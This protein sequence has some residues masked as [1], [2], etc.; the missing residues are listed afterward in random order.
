MRRKQMPKAQR[1]PYRKRSYR[2]AYKK[3]AASNALG[4]AIGSTI[5][6]ALGGAPGSVIGSALGGGA[7]SLISKI[8]GSGDY[9]VNYNVLVNEQV[10][11]FVNDNKFRETRISHKEFIQDIV[12]SATPGA[13]NIDTFVVNP[14][15]SETFPWLSSLAVNYEEYALDGIV[16]EFKSTSSNALNSTNTALGTVVMAT[17]YNSLNAPF[18]NKQQ[19]ENYEFAVSCNP[20]CNMIHPIE[21]EQF[22]NPTH[23]LYVRELD[24]AS[25]AN[26]D[27]RLYDMGNFSIA[28]VG[29]QGASVT[30]GEL[31]VSYSLRL[32]K[33]K[34]GQAS[35]VADHFI[36]DAASVTTGTWMGNVALAQLSPSSDFGIQLTQTQ[37]IIPPYFSGNIC[38]ELALVTSSISQTA[39]TFT[40]S[41]GATPLNLLFNN[42]ANT[43]I[44]P[45]SEIVTVF[46]CVSYWTCATGG[47]I[48]ISGGSTAAAG[49]CTVADL[50][51]MAISSS[52]VD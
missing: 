9:K 7:Q 22:Q 2:P 16:F 25:I 5:G 35:D 20:S 13:F 45:N 1:Q 49:A 15:V 11:Q 33:P 19:M 34:L 12:S 27:K 28:S 14:G 18:V 40:G 23:I 48:T 24:N 38:I 10:P 8:T 31:W 36:L 21:C 37:I 17:Q 3:R 30:I 41:A 47:I 32:L 44:V 43:Y 26:S 51:V 4:K 6:A 39:P 46:Q 42:G 50:V 29:L 52:L